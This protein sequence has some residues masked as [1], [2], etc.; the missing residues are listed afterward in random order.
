MVRIDSMAMPGASASLA[1]RGM[2]SSMAVSVLDYIDGGYDHDVIHGGAGDDVLYGQGGHDT[3]YGGAGD[4]VLAG[5]GRNNP[6]RVNISV[7]YL[8]GRRWQ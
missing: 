8:L 6:N 4:D 1:G 7:D 5:G 2:I 3:I